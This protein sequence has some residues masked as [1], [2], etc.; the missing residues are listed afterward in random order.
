MNTQHPGPERPNNLHPIMAMA[1]APFAPVQKHR[2]TC[3]RRRIF[4]SD[5]DARQYERGFGYWPD[6]MPAGVELS[7]PFSAGWFDH[8]QDA[9]ARDDDRLDTARRAFDLDAWGDE[10]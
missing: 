8:S 1:L 6:P 3:G 4:L 5:A 10:A 9:Q 2:A 7:T